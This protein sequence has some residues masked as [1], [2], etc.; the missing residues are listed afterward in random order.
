MAESL[1]G[2]RVLVVG[3]AGGIGSAIGDALLAR[4]LSKLIIASSSP[5]PP[6]ADRSVEILDV[7]DASS[8]QALAA[9][10]AGQPLHAVIDCAGINGRQTVT[11]P[12]WESMARREIEVNYLGMLRLAE[13]F[14]PLLAAQRDACFMVVLS[15]LSFANLPG[16]ATYCAS[17]AAA[18][19]ALQAVRAMWSPKGVRVCGVYPTAVDTAMSQDLPGPK[20]SPQAL[21]QEVVNALLSDA[22]AIFPGDA[23]AAFV[24]YLA[25][26]AGMQRAMSQD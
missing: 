11:A 4:G 12:D 17:K 1:K 2:R 26:P 15:F 10:L 13:T 7:T 20:L 19:S 25:D 5:H 9:R 6:R 21:A 14:A 3:G 23:A 24:Q 16:M 22:E 18:H 8:I